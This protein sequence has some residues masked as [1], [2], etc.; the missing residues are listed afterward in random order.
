M[1]HQ[2]RAKIRAPLQVKNKDLE[3][4]VRNDDGK[5]GTLLI[6]QGNIEWVPT[7]NKVN[8]TRMRWS[9]FAKFMEEYGRPV[10]KPNR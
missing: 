3:I 6:S 9:K 10:K 7:G 1:A 2:V 5:L 4:D 8:R